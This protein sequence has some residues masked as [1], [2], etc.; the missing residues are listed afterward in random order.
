MPLKFLE[1]LILYRH[2]VELVVA[3]RARMEQVPR[4]RRVRFWHHTALEL[5]HYLALRK[6]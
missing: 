6:L 5:Y 1:L 3:V 4:E 2:L